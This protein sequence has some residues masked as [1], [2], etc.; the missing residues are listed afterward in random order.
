M[1]IQNLMN[2]LWDIR[3]FLGLVPRESPC[4]YIWG[5]IIK[6]LR[7]ALFWVMTQRVVV[8]YQRRFGLTLFTGAHWI[9]HWAK[10][11]SRY[12]RFWK[13]KLSYFLGEFNQAL[14]ITYIVTYSLCSSGSFEHS[15]C[16]TML[17]SL[18][19]VV[20]QFLCRTGHGLSL[21]H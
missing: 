8:I 19:G 21:Y 7:T 20:F 5:W 17:L 12:G 16:D 15:V 18:L 10:P 4:I 6:E 13:E 1:H 3:I 2:S 14:S 11:R 9:G